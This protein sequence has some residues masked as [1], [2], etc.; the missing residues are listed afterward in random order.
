MHLNEAAIKAQ[1]A[2]GRGVNLLNLKT[3][4]T[5]Y[6]FMLMTE[7]LHVAGKITYIFTFIKC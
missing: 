2:N 4:I 5:P 7:A 3:V 1:T 6:I